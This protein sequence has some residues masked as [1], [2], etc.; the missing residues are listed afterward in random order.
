MGQSMADAD[1]T[2]L[3]TGRIV[4]PDG[5]SS[6][7]VR[8]KFTEGREWRVGRTA[9]AGYRKRHGWVGDE[10]E[11]HGKRREGGSGA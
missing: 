9:T 3:R 11:K 6:V 10:E 2:R 4:H 5:R 8:Q 1:F 7:D